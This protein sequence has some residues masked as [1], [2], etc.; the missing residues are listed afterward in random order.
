MS[1]DASKVITNILGF[2]GNTSLGGLMELNWV[3]LRIRRAC[4]MCLENYR[5]AFLT[6]PFLY[7]LKCVDVL[8]GF[9]CL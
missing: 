1:R 4:R 9:Q 8:T 7:I 6:F 2:R 5:P 3:N